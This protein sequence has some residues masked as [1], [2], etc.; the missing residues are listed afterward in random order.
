MSQESP[1]PSKR[2]QLIQ[3]A[4]TL[5]A[6]N[7]IHATGIDS[8]VEHSGVTKKTLYAHFRSKEELVLAAL[9][10]YDGQ[11]RNSFMRQVET[12]AR[13][14]KTRLLA[15]FDVAETWF[16]QQSFYGCLFINAVGEHSTPDTSLR[17]VCRD[18]KRMMT[19][20][21]L[22]LCIQMG[23]RNPQHLAEELSLLLEGAIVTA[24]VSQKPDAAKIAKRVA[25]ALIEKQSP[26]ETPQT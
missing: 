9:R 26:R 12:K 3:T 11:F 24:Q 4:V 22:K 1:R 25:A 8:I 19:E 20:F 15:I 14:P 7:G 10:H 16:S 13:T 6:Q 18:F 23:V 2:E 21:I 5:F 17:Y